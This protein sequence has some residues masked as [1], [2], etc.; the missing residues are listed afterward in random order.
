MPKCQPDS[1]IQSVNLERPPDF[2]LQENIILL[3][4]THSVIYF[5]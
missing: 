5:H 3:V 2:V 4:S 1:A